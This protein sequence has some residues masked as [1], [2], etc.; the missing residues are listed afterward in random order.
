MH[1]KIKSKKFWRKRRNKQFKEGKRVLNFFNLISKFL[2]LTEQAKKQK[3]ALHQN[4]LFLLICLV[5]SGTVI[6]LEKFVVQMLWPFPPFIIFDKTLIISVLLGIIGV[7]GVFLA[8]FFSAETTVFSSTYSKAPYEISQ[9]FLKETAKDI[10]PVL[11]DF[12]MS[13]MFLL[14]ELFFWDMGIVSISIYLLVSLITVCSFF[15]V[16]YY[17]FFYSKICKIA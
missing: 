4:L 17:A 15:V 11:A 14:C 8:L 12:S 7:D 16:G 9:T 2:S 1:E 10:K 13:I 6:I 3:I 5:L